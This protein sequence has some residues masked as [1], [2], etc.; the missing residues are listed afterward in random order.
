MFH[1]V[2]VPLISKLSPRV[3]QLPGTQVISPAPSHGI[4][5]I[6]EIPTT[7][8]RMSVCLKWLERLFAERI[9]YEDL[10]YRFSRNLHSR[11]AMK[12]LYRLIKRKRLSVQKGIDC[13]TG[14][15]HLP[16][17]LYLHSVIPLHSTH[18]ARRAPLWPYRAT[19]HHTRTTEDC[20]GRGWAGCSA[21]AINLSAASSRELAPG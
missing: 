4:P 21:N 16:A 17:G 7:S 8:N 2:P 3:T 6:W 5:S 15:E 13:P 18:P 9:T 19:G 20:D 12:N 11:S 14:A 10:M 1:Y